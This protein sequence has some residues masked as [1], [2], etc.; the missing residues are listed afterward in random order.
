MAGILDKRR[1]ARPALPDA[2]FATICSKLRGK[3]KIDPLHLP[4]DEAGGESDTTAVG[5]VGAAGAAGGDEQRGPGV[6]STE[7]EEKGPEEDRPASEM[8]RRV[9]DVLASPAAASA[10]ALNALVRELAATGETKAAV[11]VWDLLGGSSAA[12]PSTWVALEALHA[13]G[14]IKIP[15]G[16]LPLT[17]NRNIG[18]RARS[19]PRFLDPADSCHTLFLYRHTAAAASPGEERD[20]GPGAQS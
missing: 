14:K 16:T 13:R 1:G 3:Y 6:D 20:A 5:A 12:E 19:T 11:R 8:Q 7:A 2:E 4:D 10:A 17:Q 18:L 15:S 9:D